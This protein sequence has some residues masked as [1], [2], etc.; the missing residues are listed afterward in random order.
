MPDGF[1]AAGL[2]AL[3]CLLPPL[4]GWWLAARLRH[5][6]LFR[7]T[8]ACLAGMTT[9][10]V[11]EL[12]VFALRV[13]QWVAAAMV[14]ACAIS[15]RPVIAATRQREFAWGA[16]LTWAG[17]SAILTAATMRFAVHGTPGA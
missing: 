8:V 2:I 5:E 10:A 3:C 1:A 9:L 6:S 13:P 16:F 12:I 4:S 11:A 7:F 17:A 15:L 14:L